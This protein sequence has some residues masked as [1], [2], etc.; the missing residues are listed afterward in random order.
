MLVLW[1]REREDSEVLC[2]RNYPGLQ[3]LRGVTTIN[4][5]VMEIEG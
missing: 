4:V 1:S 5:A 3:Q 2:V